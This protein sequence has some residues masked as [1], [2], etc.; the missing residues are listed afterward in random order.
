MQK[1]ELNSEEVLFIK[2]SISAAIESQKNTRKQMPTNPVA[3]KM[4]N[5]VFFG[6]KSLLNKLF[7]A[8]EITST[9][10]YD[11]YSLIVKYQQ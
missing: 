1:I 9:T 4:V 2:L 10:Y 8:N 6:A 11:L 5:E 7:I 3:T